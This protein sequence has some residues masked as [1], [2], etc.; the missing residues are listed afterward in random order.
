MKRARLIWLTFF[1]GV[2]VTF[3]EPNFVQLERL[4]PQNFIRFGT[5]IGSY[6]LVDAEGY[7]F[8][9]MQPELAYRSYLGE[10]FSLSGDGNVLTGFATSAWMAIIQTASADYGFSSALSYEMP[11]KSNFKINYTLGYRQ[12][13][14]MFVSLVYALKRNQ[15]RDNFDTQYFLGQ[16]KTHRVYVSVDSV[17]TLFRGVGATVEFYAARLSA[18]QRWSEVM[19]HVTYGGRAEFSFDLMRS[20]KIPILTKLS[21]GI[22][23]VKTPDQRSYAKLE[24]L[25]S[26]KNDFTLGIDLTSARTRFADFLPT[27]LYAVGL[28]LRV[29][30]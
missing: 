4:P 2:N 22:G 14:T 15:N 3:G 27:R 10:G 24:I 5:A 6:S 21:A 26:F 29:N 17:L 9:Y 7:T 25:R 23:D 18:D 16:I 13:K 19:P 20:V 11:V 8:A 12:K 1:A 30:Y 28:G